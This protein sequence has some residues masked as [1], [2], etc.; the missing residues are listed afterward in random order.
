MRIL[1]QKPPKYIWKGVHKIFNLK[2]IEPAFAYG[3]AIYNP[4]GNFLDPSM[5]AHEEVHSKQQGNDPDKWWKK[6][7][8][9]PKFRLEQE[10]PAYQ[11]QYEVLNEL[12][13]DKNIVN[14]QLIRLAE[15]LSGN[16]YGNVMTANEAIKIIK[17]VT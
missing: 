2:G 8:R 5:I 9:D 10:I 12:I 13:K 1:K 14:Q 4:Y 3:D 16:M 7:L 6:Y 17:K 11:R 15:D